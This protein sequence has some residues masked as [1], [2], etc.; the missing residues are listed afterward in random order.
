MDLGRF[1]RSRLQFSLWIALPLFLMAVT[2]IPSV[3]YLRHLQKDLAAR[4]AVFDLLPAAELRARAASRVLKTVTLDAGR[5]SEGTDDATR[6]IDQAAKNAGVTVRALRFGEAP[7]EDAHFKTYL[8]IVE[9]NGTLRAVVQWLDE[10]QKPGL[11]FT[12]R[13][14]SVNAY[15]APPNEQYGGSVKLLLRLRKA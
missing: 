5:P 6:R 3:F 1:E 14:A 4:K 10:I 13:E 2:T 7:E 8:L 11:L 9:F 12:I 15:A